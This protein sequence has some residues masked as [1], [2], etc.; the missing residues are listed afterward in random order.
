LLILLCLKWGWIVIGPIF[1]DPI[2]ILI[3]ILIE[4]FIIIRLLIIINFDSETGLFIVNFI[5]SKVGM[6]YYWA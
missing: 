2:V 5:V 4:F 6:D 3:T 1:V